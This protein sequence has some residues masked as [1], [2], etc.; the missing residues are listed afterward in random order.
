[1]SIAF[2]GMTIK[3]DPIFTALSNSTLGRDSG[4]PVDVTKKDLAEFEKRGDVRGFRASI[5]AEDSQGVRH[6]NLLK[7]KVRGL[8]N[9]LSSLQLHE[10][11]K[12]YFK[13][14]DKL[15]PLGKPTGNATK[16]ASHP[17]PI[18][19]AKVQ[20]RYRQQHL[21][22]MAAVKIG[23]FF[24]GRARELEK[25]KTDLKLNQFPEQDLAQYVHMLV[26]Y[27]TYKPFEE[28]LETKAQTEQEQTVE[29]RITV[30]L[31][32]KRSRCLLGCGTYGYRS[33]LTQHTIQVHVRKG[34]F[35]SPFCCPE[36]RRL[37]MKDAWI[38]GGPSAWSNHV[39]R[40][41]GKKHAPNLPSH[42]QSAAEWTKCLICERLLTTG[43]GSKT[44]FRLTHVNKGQFEGQPFPC[45]ECIR[46]GREEVERIKDLDAWDDHVERVH[47]G[48]QTLSGEVV[49]SARARRRK[50]RG[51]K[52]QALIET[53][54]DSSRRKRRRISEGS[55]RDISEAPTLV[56]V[57]T[58]PSPE[59]TTYE[60]DE[61]ASRID[62]RLLEDG[63]KRE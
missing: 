53:D 22:S 54:N 38:E 24:Q 29:D 1:M 33:A 16:P 52:A 50:G 43:S 34:T 49:Q 4:A 10:N 18:E 58:N 36:C 32:D 14:V 28:F 7:M 51:R 25:V 35:E 31:D 9:T 26:A 11:R 57:S 42:P 39:E 61:I 23:H 17:C 21:R 13:R 8:I 15:R 6:V 2:D 20:S 63:V 56:D 48:T 44:H 27:L 41:H 55:S 46:Q 47:G 5:K 37:G 3:S 62:P 40:I 60:D 59:R 45:P 12:K 19:A 30:E